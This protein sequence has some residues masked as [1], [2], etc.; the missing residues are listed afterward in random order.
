MA[1]RSEGVA[2]EK[3][4]FAFAEVEGGFD[5]LKKSGL[6]IGGQGE[7]LLAAEKKR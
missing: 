4:N 3:V 1:D 2:A 7:A 5:R 6:L